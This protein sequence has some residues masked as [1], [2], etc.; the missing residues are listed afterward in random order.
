MNDS[1]ES[2]RAYKQAWKQ[3]DRRTRRR[4]SRLAQKGDLGTN[5][6]ESQWVVA[7]SSRRLN[8]WYEK[9]FVA[10]PL[11]V[12]IYV[13]LAVTVNAFFGW[14]AGGFLG[15]LAAYIYLVFTTREKM[16]RAIGMNLS[17]LQASQWAA[18]E[19]Q[20]PRPPIGSEAPP[21]PSSDTSPPSS[22]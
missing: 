21:A 12:L 6:W 10:I 5:P 18:P 1:P 17:Q 13:L 2:S 22:V 4:I 11:F 20:A 3:L 8:S 7:Y 15:G 14:T 19:R 9:P 16:R